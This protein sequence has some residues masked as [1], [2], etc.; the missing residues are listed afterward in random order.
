MHDVWTTDAY[1]EAGDF[2]RFEVRDENGLEICAAL[3][4]D[5][6]SIVADHNAAERLRATLA[7]LLAVT[8]TNASEFRDTYADESGDFQKGEHFDCA[9]EYE[10]R[11]A[12]LRE[13]LALIGEGT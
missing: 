8:E 9:L 5:A 1:P 4:D 12:T 7:E 3:R 11:A 13:V 6:L 2:S 10:T